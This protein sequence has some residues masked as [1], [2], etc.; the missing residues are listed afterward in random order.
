[1]PEAA[2]LAGL[3]FDQCRRWR[4]GDR[5]PV[6][7]YLAQQP[8]LRADAEAVLELIYNEI[9]LREETSSPPRL[10]EYLARFPAFG[11]QLR[12]QFDV[13]RAIERA[14]PPSA[15]SLPREEPSTFP[16]G[17]RAEPSPSVH[18]P[19][20]EILGLVGRG[21]MGMVYKARQLSL[22]RLVALKMIRAAPHA[23]PRELA[24]A[25]T[26]AEAVARLRHPH[27]VQIYEVGEHDG[28]PYFALELVDGPDLETATAG[29]ALPAALAARLVQTLAGAVQHAHQQGIIHRDLKPAN[30]LLGF[31][32]DAAAERGG[33]TRSAAA[34]RLNEALPKIADFGL[35]KLLDA[36]T[37]PT[38]TEAF[39]GTPGY[40]APEQ[41]A[42][43]A[44]DIGP[45]A[46]VFALGAI[47][48]RLLTGQ[49]PFRGET[50]LETLDQ[51]RSHDPV[52][53]SRL[54]PDVPRD[55]ET[56]CLKCLHK[57][58]RRRYAAAGDL[59]DDLR[60]FLAGEPIRARPASAGERLLKWAKRR[61]T[62]AALLA[63]T[64]AA[65]IALGGLTLR[66][67]AE[68]RDRERFGRADERRREAGRR[69]RVR[70]NYREFVRRRDDALFHG[71]YA[72]L[73]SD[74]DAPAHLRTA[75]RAVHQALA[76][77]AVD[78]PEGYV[79]DPH[80]S[81]QENAE[82]RAGCYQ[83]LLVLAE[84]VQCRLPDQA[85][86]ERARQLRLALAVLERAAGL[87]P[88]TQAYH[89]RRA[90]YLALLGDT[91]AA[92][93]AREAG[94]KL[95]P[96]DFSD[97]FLLGEEWTRQG[98]FAA[99]VWNFEQ[100]LRRQPDDF[101]SHFLTAYGH[102]KCEAPAE[103]RPSLDACLARRPRFVWAHLLQAAV[104]EESGAAAAA[105]ASYRR[106][107]AL[108]PGAEARFI[109]HVSRGRM[110][111][112]RGDLPAAAADFHRA[113]ALRPRHVDIY[114]ELARV[115]RSRRDLAA[116]DRQ[117]E[118]ALRLEPNG[119]R[120]AQCHTERGRNLLLGRRYAA[121]LRALDDA[122]RVDPGEADSHFL[123]ARALL[124]LGRYGE[125]ARSLERFRR[126]GGKAGPDFYRVR[127]RARLHT[128][129]YPGAVDD[130]S[131]V[132][133]GR[134]DTDAYLN[135][136]W[137]YFFADAWKLALRDFEEAV[138]RGPR[139]ADALAG[140]GLARVM[141][142]RYRAAVR[143]GE[144]ALRERP[145]TPETMHNVACLFALAV[146]R[147][148][149]DPGAAEQRVLA[150]RLRERALAAVRGT[151]ALVPPPQRAA[152]W[153]DKIRPDRALDAIHG[154]P[155]FEQIGKQINLP[156]P[157]R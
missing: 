132:L 137:A 116:A 21:G 63:V 43:K 67:H 129:D 9:V 55:L 144:A 38:P 143:D 147:V 125:A 146:G 26:E 142:G 11:A 58:P 70:R 111:G 141:L 48:Y 25:R 112:R 119:R 71:V 133:A 36:D 2:H 134:P 101:W 155:A 42:G 76:A 139:R 156:G 97:F 32:R 93:R 15:V 120:L 103:A 52:P 149:N 87:L 34:S 59:G 16:D 45:P 69:Q 95:P 153:R 49:A 151:L 157:S 127:G 118:R 105:E 61:P 91:R 138:R 27:I 12:L 102:L 22:K 110:R 28:L 8:G 86:A 106:A 121:A 90:R 82:V 33:G 17:A 84:A 4:Q 109:L 31:S 57:D 53:P 77:V 5:V 35:A 56:I 60:A 37:G 29:R 115:Y 96:A 50:V 68:A 20:Y 124:E 47:L 123:R 24:R 94:A 65:A 89:L 13:H 145:A 40:M 23:G 140:R 136:G 83:L 73:F 126:Q 100:A 130:S 19:G 85:P 78:S 62:A 39:V 7:T 72:T 88:P 10:E 51:I 135:R 75:R 131:R 14:C 113:I 3:R 148:E 128:G 107:L 30:V 81:D 114:L 54:R 1:M 150:A 79:P 104:H 154:C 122:L 66:H 117:L 74:L 46:D 152:F 64:A 80:L 98:N 92:R 44:R 18:V 6:E 99:A 108:G 41:A